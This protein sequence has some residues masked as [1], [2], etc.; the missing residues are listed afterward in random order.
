MLKKR[1]DVKKIIDERAM[2]T[3]KA[4]EIIYG[5][6]YEEEELMTEKMGLSYGQRRMN[7]NNLNI[8]YAKSLKEDLLNNIFIV[9]MLIEKTNK[10]LK[11]IS[12][13]EVKL[14]E[15]I[16]GHIRH[17]SIIKIVLEELR[18]M[19]NKEEMVKSIKKDLNT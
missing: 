16:N 18:D 5:F 8:W 10:T 13:K 4:E 6:T 9:S 2:R 1:N 14:E 15:L 7:Q 11:I 17:N 12:K 3:K 19:F